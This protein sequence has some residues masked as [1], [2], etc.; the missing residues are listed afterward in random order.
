LRGKDG[1]PQ[2]TVSARND[3]EGLF[4]TQVKAPYNSLPTEAEKK[5]VFKFFD[6]MKPIGFK[7]KIVPEKYYNT[8]T[9]ES[10]DAADRPLV[11]WAEEYSRYTK[12]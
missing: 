10:L 8:R 11:N 9:G 7:S 5:E 4:I 1:M 3:P 2:L 12:E 6:A